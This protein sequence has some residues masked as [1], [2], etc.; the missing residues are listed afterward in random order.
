M[1]V[2]FLEVNVINVFLQS[3]VQVVSDSVWG[4]YKGEE[5]WR[6]EVALKKA[7]SKAHRSISVVTSHI[8]NCLVDLSTSASEYDEVEHKVEDASRA[9]TALDID[10]RAQR[11]FTAMLFC[12]KK[13]TFIFCFCDVFQVAIVLKM[14]VLCC[15]SILSLV[16]FL[17][18]FV[19]F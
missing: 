17:F 8:H 11:Q 9:S 6:K 1:K 14:G 4:K 19:L 13:V 15:G 3:K 2:Q 5:R 18:F 16:Q 12:C 7:M 10:H